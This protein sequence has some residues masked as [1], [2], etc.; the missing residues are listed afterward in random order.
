M[1]DLSKKKKKKKT[2]LPASY[3]IFGQI[4]KDLVISLPKDRAT[5]DFMKKVLLATW[6]FRDG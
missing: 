1:F 2:F 6:A 4:P 5:G 3:G